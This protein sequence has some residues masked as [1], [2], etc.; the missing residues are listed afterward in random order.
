MAS[1]SQLSEAKR[2]ELLRLLQAWQDEIWGLSIYLTRWRMYRRFEVALRRSG[3]YGK[4]AL[5]SELYWLCCGHIH[6]T[7]SYLERRTFQIL[8]KSLWRVVQ[9]PE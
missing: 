8:A 6:T 4:R 7:G 5:F 1:V 2:Q 3:E 9:C